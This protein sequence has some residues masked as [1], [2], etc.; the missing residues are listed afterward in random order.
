MDFRQRLL[1]WAYSTD[2]NAA[3]L[4]Y[5]IL[6]KCFLRIFSPKT[7]NKLQEKIN[8]FS[9]LCKYIAHKTKLQLLFHKQDT[10]CFR[11]STRYQFDPAIPLLKNSLYFQHVDWNSQ[12]PTFANCLW[13]CSSSLSSYMVFWLSSMDIRTRLP[14]LIMLH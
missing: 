7:S 9:Q 8:P 5:Q 1:S 10:N 14:F 3:S 2:Q 4:L 12:C 11:R 6:I 13:Y